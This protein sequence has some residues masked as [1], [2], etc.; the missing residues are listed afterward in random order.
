MKTIVITMLSIFALFYLT[1]GLS[2]M[3]LKK[4]KGTKIYNF[5]KKHIITDE[6]LESY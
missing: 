3:V 1:V 4:M 5:V 2:M 6:D